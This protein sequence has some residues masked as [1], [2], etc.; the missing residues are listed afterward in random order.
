MSTIGT[1]LGPQ[2]IGVENCP[3]CGVTHP[4]LMQAWSS[5]QPLE[6][7]TPGM[8][9]AWVIYKCISCGSLVTARGQPN[10]LANATTVTA[11]FPQAKEVHMDVPEPARTFLNQ[12][13][14]TLHAP[15][16]AAMVAGSAV[17]AMLKNLGYKEGSV[18][19]R[20]TQAVND[21]KL[22]EGMGAWAHEVRLGSNRPRHADD[23]KPH[24][25]PEEAKQ[26]VE[27][28]EALAYFL[29]VLTKQIERG[30]AAAV[31]AA[32]KN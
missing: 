7:A 12:A 18:Y 23:E 14:Q 31:K 13:F 4:A 6:R 25:T 11:I 1:P 10:Q 28:A 3:H 27:F 32:A 8:R 24:I 22:T 29:F 21:H 2:L 9:Y 19:A 30:T 15:D 26:S 17:D 5:G 16:A 20:I